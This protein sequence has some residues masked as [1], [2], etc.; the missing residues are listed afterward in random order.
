[1][2]RNFPGIDTSF[3]SACLGK[4]ADGPRAQ[5]RRILGKSGK[6]FSIKKLSLLGKSMPPR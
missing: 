1:V 6:L 2:K 5:E 4:R 3:L